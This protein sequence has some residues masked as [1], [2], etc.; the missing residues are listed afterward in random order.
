MGRLFLSRQRRRIGYTGAGAA[1]PGLGRTRLDGFQQ[2]LRD[3]GASTAEAEIL[4]DRPSFY[5]GYYGAQNLLS[6]HP[7]LDAIYFQNDEMAVGGMAYCQAAGLDVPGDIGIAGWGGMDVATILPR[8]LTTTNV[9]T[10][11]LGKAAAEALASRIRGEPVLEVM[12]I[13]SS[14]APGDNIVDDTCNGASNGAH[15]MRFHRRSKQQVSGCL[16]RVRSATSDNVP[17]EI[18]P[19]TCPSCKLR[20]RTSK[21]ITARRCWRA[22]VA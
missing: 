2:A 8:R 3:T 12:E 14:L 11:A 15:Q 19:V 5:Q 6:R 1:A 20:C 10:R 16:E 17:H 7:D 21:R 18:E 9:S 13:R 4:D 22:I